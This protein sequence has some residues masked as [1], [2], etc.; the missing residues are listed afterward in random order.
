VNKDKHALG[1]ALRGKPGEPP[2]L[3][4]KTL[5]GMNDE[6]DRSLDGG[7]SDTLYDLQVHPLNIIF[8]IIISNNF[9][10]LD[11]RVFDSYDH[12]MAGVTIPFLARV[13]FTIIRS[14]QS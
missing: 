11:I 8:A 12:F 4:R 7:F 3:R 2:Y 5:I 10:G 6:R 1:R 9:I 13:L 14:G